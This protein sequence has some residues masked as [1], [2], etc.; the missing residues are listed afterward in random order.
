ML[1][2]IK[3][4]RRVHH[5]SSHEYLRVVTVQG[6]GK[7]ET[8]VTNPESVFYLDSLIVLSTLA[9]RRWTRPLSVNKPLFLATFREQ[10][11]LHRLV[12]ILLCFIFGLSF[13]C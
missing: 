4:I 13:V 3:S 2:W 11:S 10:A 1:P 9:D 8:I 7:G 6:E 5:R 12:C